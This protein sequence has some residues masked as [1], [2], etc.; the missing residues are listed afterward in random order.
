MLVLQGASPCSA[1]E[2]LKTVPCWQKLAE[3]G[4][5][6]GRSLKTYFKPSRY[7]HQHPPALTK[8]ALSSQHSPSG[9]A[10]LTVLEEPCARR[11]QQSRPGGRDSS[12]WCNESPALRA[13]SLGGRLAHH[14]LRSSGG[15][16]SLSP[17]DPDL[18]KAEA[19]ES[20]LSSTEALPPQLALFLHNRVPWDEHPL[21]S[22]TPHEDAN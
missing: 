20:S 16:A 18:D 2:H 22:V 9:E 1:V 19:F 15:R 3:G 4:R 6:G 13:E 14:P 21:V 8:W 17:P 12:L 10:S 11:Q 7:R 5:E